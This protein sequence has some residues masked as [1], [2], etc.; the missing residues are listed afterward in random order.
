MKIIGGAYKIRKF[1]AFSVLMITLLVIGIYVALQIKYHSL[2][3]S[4]KTYLVNIEGYAESDILSVKAK[5]GSMPKFPLYVTFADD[6]GTTYIFTDRDA[7][8]WTQLDPKV[9]QRLKKDN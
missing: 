1:A 5:L 9:P 6:P 8:D 3:T 7:S 2:E 4:L